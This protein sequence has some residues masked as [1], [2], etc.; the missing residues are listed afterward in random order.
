[1][2]HINLSN[3]L[4]YSDL[5]RISDLPAADRRSLRTWLRRQKVPVPCVRV[6]GLA[7]AEQDLVPTATV[8]RWALEKALARQP[9]PRHT[10]LTG[11][12]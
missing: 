3:W 5:C 1:M 12:T 6:P 2:P 7:D 4:K 8:A 10:K 9:K 11:P